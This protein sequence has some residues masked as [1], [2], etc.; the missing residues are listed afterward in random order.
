MHWDE[1]IQRMSGFLVILPL[2]YSL[3][4]PIFFLSLVRSIS[5]DLF[6][7]GFYL[8]FGF[9]T[10]SVRLCLDSLSLMLSKGMNFDCQ[11]AMGNE[12]VVKIFGKR[13]QKERERGKINFTESID[14]KW[15][16]KG[17]AVFATRNALFKTNEAKHC[18]CACVLHF[19]R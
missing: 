11:N 19:N 3:Y 17:C 18:V 12:I 4:F 14:R 16:T 8:V 2:R 6:L 5:S 1:Q 13:K 7:F 9:S 10:T 15:H